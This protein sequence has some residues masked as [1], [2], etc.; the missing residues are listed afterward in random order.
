L[1]TE[2]L[3]LKIG[4]IVYPLFNDNN[5]K[6]FA[7]SCGVFAM[8]TFHF[9]KNGIKIDKITGAD[10]HGL[11]AMIELHATPVTP[12]RPQGGYRLGGGGEGGPKQQ[13]TNQP[14]KE[15]PTQT[16]STA[17]SNTPTPGKPMSEEGKYQ[18][19]LIQ[20]FFFSISSSSSS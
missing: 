14:K 19:L 7:Q 17:S 9:Y 3:F 16:P 6:S 12:V 4:T 2:I 10:I 11:Q 18:K 15:E 8:P 20:D 13:P 1:R 5:Q